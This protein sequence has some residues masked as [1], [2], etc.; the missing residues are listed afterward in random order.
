MLPRPSQWNM[1]GALVLPLRCLGY[2]LPLAK[3]MEYD[4][5]SGAYFGMLRRTTA[6]FKSITSF[7]SPK[8]E[9]FARRTVDGDLRNSLKAGGWSGSRGPVIDFGSVNCRVIAGTSSYRMHYHP[10]C[11]LY[12]LHSSIMTVM[13]MFI[14]A[15]TP[16]P[17]HKRSYI[18]WTSKNICTKN[19]TEIGKFVCLSPT[20]Y[21]Y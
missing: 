13:S 10:D 9:I 11:S 17:H 5:G 4:S 1:I 2:L 16:L 15:L 21:V 19:Y 3:S 12:P 20:A 6:S 14:L 8:L 7:S 18:L